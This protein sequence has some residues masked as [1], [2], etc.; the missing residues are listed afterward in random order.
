MK[1]ENNILS[2]FKPE[3]YRI[4]R[5]RMIESILYTDMAHHA[6]IMSKIKAKV[7]QFEI[8]KGRNVEKLINSDHISKTFENQ[9]QILGFCLH[10]AD[11]STPTKSHKLAKIWGEMIYL[12]FFS[13][14]DIEKKSDMPVSSLCDRYTTN[15]NKSQVGFI[16]F[17]VAPTFE[18]LYRFIPEIYQLL[19]NL[20]DNLKNYENLV[21]AD[22]IQGQKSIIP[23]KK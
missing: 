10:A 4:C 15:I 16:N 14:G 5:K 8:R 12:E 13:Q 2:N 21:K 1:E 6:K 17:V 19:E 20:K 9:Q 18:L 3:E 22:E 23:S 7:E 11:I